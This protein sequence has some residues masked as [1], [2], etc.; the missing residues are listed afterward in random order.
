MSK[1]FSGKVILVIGGNSG[2]GLAAARR[3]GDEG[4][5]VVI[6]GRNEAT[7]SAAVAQIPGCVGYRTDISD[8]RAMEP[9][10]EKI[11]ATHGR[12]DVLFV[13]AGVGGFTPFREMTPEHWDAIH[14]VDLR[15]CV[16]AAQAGLPLLGRGA[17]IIFNGSIA[18]IKNPPNGL[19]YV[20]AKSGLRGAVRAIAAELVSVGVRVNLVSPGPTDTPIIGRNIGMPDADIPALRAHMAQVVPMNRMGTPEEIANAVLFLA[21]EE[22]SFITGADLVVDGGCVIV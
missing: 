16:F 10:I 13:N 21:S 11:K 1:R 2:I 22:A 7:L 3:F 5:P 4:G 8:T 6:T 17:S 12:I 20:A 9:V 14:G 15:G 18:A 19:A